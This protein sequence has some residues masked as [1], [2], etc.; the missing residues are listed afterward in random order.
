LHIQFGKPGKELKKPVALLAAVRV[1]NEAS[2]IAVNLQ[3]PSWRIL[4]LPRPESGM[5]FFGAQNDWRNLS[6]NSGV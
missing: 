4:T 6:P 1:A 3:R 2:A 5:N